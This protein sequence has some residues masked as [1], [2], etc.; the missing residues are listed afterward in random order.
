LFLITIL[1]DLPPLVALGIETALQS[2]EEPIRVDPVLLREKAISLAQDG[3]VDLVVVDPCRPTLSE[4]LE[5]CKELKAQN[6]PPYVIALTCLSDRRALMYCLLAGIDSF[7]SCDQ[8][9]QRFAAAARSTLTGNREWLLG[10]QAER[11]PT[12]LTDAADLTPREQ[13]VLW[14]LRERYT[15]QQIGSALSISTNTAKNHVAAV[16]RKLGLQRRSH[17]FRGPGTGTG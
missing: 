14:M 5:F 10:S 1:V 15:N 11:P 7:V 2:W 16:L 6:C 9:P 4:G 8:P 3:H 12:E 17:L 13:E